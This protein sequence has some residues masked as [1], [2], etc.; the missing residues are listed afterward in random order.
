MKHLM[1]F[2]VLEYTQT[3]QARKRDTVVSFP[4]E[5][6]HGAH[7]ASLDM[8]AP[9]P[10]SPSTLLNIIKGTHVMSGIADLASML[11]FVQDMCMLGNCLSNIKCHG[12]MIF[13]VKTMPLDVD[14]H[15]H[16]YIRIGW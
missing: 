7:C 9:R 12:W 11:L 10:L 16:P 1:S 3:G 5:F 13:W 6:D 15:P 14:E 8:A 4:L 2:L